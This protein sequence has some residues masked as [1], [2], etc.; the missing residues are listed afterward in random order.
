MAAELVEAAAARRRAAVPFELRGWHVLAML[1]AF[2]ALVAGANASLTYFAF[3]TMPGLDVPNGYVTSQQY[4]R[5]IGAARAQDGRRWH[6]D[7]G[8][9]LAPG[10]ASIALALTGGSGLPLDG[11]AAKA[12]LQHPTDARL[13]ASLTLTPKGA[14][15]Y[16]GLAANIAAGPRDVIVQAWEPGGDAPAFTSRQ[17][18]YLRE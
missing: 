3:R 4:N 1:A 12:I 10:G 9:S 6:G 15:R 5:E 8:V 2:F 18:V 16:E 14:G 7:L 11:L 13:D 17:R